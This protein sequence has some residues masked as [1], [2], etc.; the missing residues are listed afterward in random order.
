MKLAGAAAT[1]TVPGVSVPVAGRQNVKDFAVALLISNSN[2]NHSLRTE[3]PMKQL[4]NTLY[5]N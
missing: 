1:Q 5:T 3:V 2:S 4:Q